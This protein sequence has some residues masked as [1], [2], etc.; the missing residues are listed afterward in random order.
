MELWVG[1]KDA[2]YENNAW[3]GLTDAGSMIAFDQASADSITAEQFEKLVETENV[4]TKTETEEN[5]KDENGNPTD[6]KE[7]VDVKYETTKENVWVRDFSYVDETGAVD[8]EDETEDET[9]DTV[10]EPINWLLFSSLIMSVAVIIF[11][12]AMICKK[13]KKVQKQAVVEEDPDYKK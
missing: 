2:K 4:F 10:V 11:L 8:V 3:T 12:I 6:E 5:V 7:V 13:F 1:D 9:D